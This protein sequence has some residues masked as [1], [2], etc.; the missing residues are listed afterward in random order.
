GAPGQDSL[1][2]R[3][4]MRPRWVPPALATVAGK[5]LTGTLV[6][7]VVIGFTLVYLGLTVSRS[8]Q[9]STNAPLAPG[10]GSVL[11][12]PTPTEIAPTE[13]APTQIAPTATNTI[14]PPT[15]YLR[16]T[17]NQDYRY[18]CLNRPIN[19][20]VT[21]L[22]VGDQAVSWEL[23]F[24]SVANPYGPPF[25]GVVGGKDT[26]QDTSGTLAVGQSITL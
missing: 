15:T 5:V 10:R 12:T 6:A 2:D 24:P 1:R 17:Q 9:G 22:D 25:W 26:P 16:V 8:P 11:P 3:D 23:V 13:I 20:P 14:A 18:A 21:L 7:A 4:T 19:Y